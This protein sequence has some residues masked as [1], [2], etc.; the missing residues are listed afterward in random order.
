MSDRITV[1]KQMLESDPENPMVLFGLANEY[2]KAGDN[3]AAINTLEDY[4]KFQT[5]EGAAY[6]MLAK[7]YEAIGE[8]EKAKAA[9]ENG[10]EVSIAN[11]HPSMASDYR[12]TLDIDY[13]E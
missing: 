6:G 4:L 12:M 10:I 9:Y 1:F 3:E 8:E 11:G 2:V 5:D 7:A 13:A